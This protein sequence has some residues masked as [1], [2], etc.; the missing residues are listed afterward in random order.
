ME[1]HLWWPGPV[2]WPLMTRGH[3]VQNHTAARRGGWKWAMVQ[4]RHRRERSPRQRCSCRVLHRSSVCRRVGWGSGFSGISRKT[5]FQRNSSAANVYADF[6]LESTQK[7]NRP[8]MSHILPRPEVHIWCFLGTFQGFLGGGGGQR[9]KNAFRR[10]RWSAAPQLG[11]LN[12]VWWRSSTSA[13][14]DED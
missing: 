8:H 7:R 3:M 10:L 6:F 13:G 12:W 1:L 4:E 9:F 2:S 11:I 5:H 14:V